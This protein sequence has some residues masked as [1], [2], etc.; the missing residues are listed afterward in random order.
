[1]SNTQD[2]IGHAEVAFR[3]IIQ[4]DALHA[5][6]AALITD[7]ESTSITTAMLEQAK[8]KAE[9]TKRQKMAV[10]KLGN[11]QERVPRGLYTMIDKLRRV[12][13]GTTSKEVHHDGT[14]TASIRGKLAVINVNQVFQQA[15]QSA[16][17]EMLQ[18]LIVESHE[19]VHRVV[20]ENVNKIL[21]KDMPYKTTVMDRFHDMAIRTTDLYSDLCKE[22]MIAMFAYAKYILVKNKS[23][24]AIM[25]L[26]PVD[27]DFSLLEH[28]NSGNTLPTIN[29]STISLEDQQQKLFTLEHIQFLYTNTF[30]RG[31]LEKTFQKY[32]MW[33]QLMVDAK[34][35]P[36]DLKTHTRQEVVTTL[37]TNVQ[38]MYEH[39]NIT[40]KLLDKVLPIFFNA[41]WPYYDTSDRSVLPTD[42]SHTEDQELQGD[43]EEDVPLP[44]GDLDLYTAE[45]ADDEIPLP[46]PIRDDEIP[47]PL[48]I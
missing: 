31:S 28:Y 15:V 10:A 14:L 27:F 4:R 30:G 39:G 18:S 45:A 16:T 37:S 12:S 23:C 40:R 19:K 41:M 7:D 34:R 1:M 11:V 25:D 26:L 33:K 46:L 43:N 38:N 35:K 6:K 42:V 24:A 8:L 29:Q 13:Q 36:C 47:L 20:S 22:I 3:S 32:P 17:I 2:L 44:T 48:P 5:L 21:L 9:V